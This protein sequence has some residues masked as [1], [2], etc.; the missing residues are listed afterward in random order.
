LDDVCIDGDN[1]VIID[2]PPADEVPIA[3]NG[4]FF[5]RTG[6]QTI[7]MSGGDI[8]AFFEEGKESE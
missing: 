1:I 8:R 2:V 5:I 4:I 7:P 3:R 6:P